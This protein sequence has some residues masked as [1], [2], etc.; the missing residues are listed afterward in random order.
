MSYQSY[1]F[2]SLLLC[3]PLCHADGGSSQNKINCAVSTKVILYGETAPAMT[4][5]QLK[6]VCGLTLS[7]LRLP[8]SKKKLEKKLFSILNA[9]P[10]TVDTI[11]QMKASIRAF[12]ADNAHPFVLVKV[13]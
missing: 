7:G 13:P 10:I 4:S 12:Y 9:G 11:E 3:A 2:A 5:N 6:D 8:G 1:L